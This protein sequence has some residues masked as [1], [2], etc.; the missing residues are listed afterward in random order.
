MLDESKINKMST[1]EVILEYLK[2]HRG[3]EI[4][5]YEI[6]QRFNYKLARISNA[7]KELDLSGEIKVERRPLKKGKYT[8]ISL[9]GDN[10]TQFATHERD[11]IRKE[12]IKRTEDLESLPVSDAIELL[13]SYY[14]NQD[15]FESLIKPYYTHYFSLVFSVIQ[16][17][18][19]EVGNK[20]ENG[21]LTIA[22]EHLIAKRMEKFVS[23]LIKPTQIRPSKTI[24][25]APVEHEQHNLPLLTLELLLVEKG[26]NVI[27]LSRTIN[28]L[29]II[30]FIKK[31][32][33]KPD[34]I[35]FSAT[36]SAYINNLRMD[37]LSLRKEFHQLQI[38][39]GGQG[40]ATIDPKD[41]TEAD[42]VVKTDEELVEFLNSL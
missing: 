30:S 2:D 3:R 28:I 35:F 12:S 6:Q 10:I 24:I 40:F 17:I 20:W 37:I 19:Y 13:N 25:L 41:F 5:I 27:N 39:V 23:S 31:M 11:L 26:C 16:P 21:E 36:M 18:M 8:I 15:K 7:I 1:R 9:M 22:D 29:S 38:A 42:I 4:P 14:Y 32:K 33:S 34:W